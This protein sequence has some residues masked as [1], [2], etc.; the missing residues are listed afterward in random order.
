MQKAHCVVMDI[1]DDDAVEG[2]VA[3]VKLGMALLVALALL[4]W[5]AAAIFGRD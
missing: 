5:T 3:T 2:L 1:F 4:L